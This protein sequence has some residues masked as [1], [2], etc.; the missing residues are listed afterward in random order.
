MI[1]ASV[2]YPT[3]KRADI[4]T[5]PLDSL[6][7]Q[8]FPKEDFEVIVVDNN[9][10]DNT[11]E[12]VKKWMDEHDGQMN[13]RYLKELRQG[14]GYARNSGAAVAKGEYLLFADD[15][16]LFD[17]NWVSCIVKMLDDYPFVGMA[18]TRI[19]IQWDEEPEP[20]VKRYEPYLAKS[21]HAK[22]G[23]TISSVGFPLANCSLGIRK[24]VFY[25]VGG[26]NPGQIGE[27]L[28]GNAELGLFNKVSAL[29]YGTAFCDDVVMWHQQRKN[30]NGRLEDIVRR[31][32]N[33]AVSDAY[34]QIFEKNEVFYYAT[35]KDFLTMVWKFMRM[36]RTACRIAYIRWRA[37]RNF[38]K[39]IK[40]YQKQEFRDRVF[41]IKDHSLGPDYK[42]PDVLKEIRYHE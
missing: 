34:T 29:G 10:P 30:K 2:I 11:E 1:K 31:L 24:E 18:G 14:D 5:D 12:V 39:W 40:N 9:S 33:D 32:E 23:Y 17:P 36:K 4:C 42:V 8:D 7:K 37:H 26:N 38:N 3:Y 25:K 13:V 15:D 27:Y 19:L 35:W 22:Y 21:V 41:N 28:V 20:W 6:L 16:S